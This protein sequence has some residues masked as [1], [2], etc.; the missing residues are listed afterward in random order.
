[1]RSRTLII[2]LTLAMTAVAL[3]PAAASAGSGQV[4]IFQDDA[5]LV[6]NGNGTREST[7]DEIRALGADTIKA[8]LDWATVAPGGKRKPSGFDAT[9]PSDYPG[10]ARYDEFLAAAEARGFD[11]IF[12]LSPPAPSWATRGRRGAF[13]QTDRPSAREFGR[14]AEAAAKRY[15]SVRVWS[16]WNEPN[17]Y[18]YLLP[19]AKNGVPVAPHLYREMVR[20]GVAGLRRGGA[21]GDKILFGELLPIGV[22]STGP[23]RNLKPL[24][25]LREMFCVDSS[26]RPFSGRAARLR[27]CNRYKKLTG[28]S[29]FAY[30]PYTRGCGPLCK[31]EQSGDDATIRVLSRVTRALDRLR[32]KRR[33]GGPRLPIWI[34]EFDFQSDPP[35]RYA[36][37]IKRIPTY[38]GIS[39]LWQAMPNSRVAAYSQYTMNDTPGDESFWQG[40]LRFAD[41]RQKKSVY[42]AYRLPILVRRLGSGAVEVRGAA[43]PGGAGAVVQV[44]Q[45]AGRGGFEDLGGP[46]RVRNKRGYF[47]ARFRI[48]NAS[49]RSY[50]FSSGGHTSPTVKSLSLFR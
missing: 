39:E 31:Q 37:P 42:A 19:Q 7:L 10:W 44:Q 38:M 27:G 45:R 21:K 25:F 28:L 46:I 20:Q 36:T 34:T 33:I 40:G 1:M 41:G 23:K 14:F 48:S 8:Q 2:T 26:Y 50:R 12:A 11:V 13:E 18:K 16:L 3:L 29:G 43:R 35:D 15:P 47:T 5:L 9:D 4:A 22:S 17:L 6:A 49:K 24:R 32:A 30:H